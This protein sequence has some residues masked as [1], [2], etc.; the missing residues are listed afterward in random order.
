MDGARRE[1]AV[2]PRRDDK[3]VAYAAHYFASDESAYVTGPDLVID[4]G[5][6]V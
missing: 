1:V 5:F 2:G 6:T 4:G 3:E